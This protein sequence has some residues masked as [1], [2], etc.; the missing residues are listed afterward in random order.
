MSVAQWLHSPD[1][2]ERMCLAGVAASRTPDG[3]AIHDL[4]S[5]AVRRNPR[6]IHLLVSKVLGKHIPVD[7]R[8]VHR[9][10]LELGRL[11]RDSLARDEQVTPSQVLVLGNAETAT[12]LGHSVADALDAAYLHSTRRR[13]PDLP[14]AEE[15]T[16]AHSHAPGHLLQPADPTL[17]DADVVVIVDDELTTGAT[18]LET[19]AAFERLRSGRRYVIATLLDMR[20][21]VDQARVP[22]A[23]TRLGARIEVV[24]LA[25]GE[26]ELAPNAAQLARRLFREKP[27]AMLR[28]QRE[29]RMPGEFEIVEV[30]WPAG[31]PLGGRHGFSV[32]HRAALERVLP[33]LGEQLERVLWPDGRLE[34][35][36]LFLGVEELM[37]APTRLAAALV[38]TL[39][40]RCPAQRVEVRISST[41]RS[42][43][44]VLDAKDYPIRTR[45]TF[46]AHDGTGGER[47]AYNVAAGAGE[48][49]F[50][51]IVL[52]LD[53]PADSP[54]LR[55]RGGLL[56]QLREVADRVVL[57]R[58]PEFRSGGAYSGAHPLPQ[59]LRG[60]GFGSYAPDEVGWLITDLSELALEAPTAEREAAVQSGRAHYAESLPVEY[61]PGP[62]YLAL[63]ADSLARNAP[64]VAHAVGTV[65][66]SIRE[67][68]GRNVVL[69]SLARAGTPVG[70]LLRRWLARHGPAPAHYAVSIVRGRGIDPVALRWLA[71]HHDPAE[72]VFV[73]GWTG[74]G[75]I[76]SELTTALAAHAT[77][78]GPRFDPRLAVLA[79]PGGAAPLVGT[80]ADLL[81]PSACLNSTVSGLVSR[82]VLRADLIGPDDFHGAKF[83]SNLAEHDHS[84]RF[85]DAITAH[86]D[87]VAPGVAPLPLQPVTW[88]GRT[89]VEAICRDERVA[90][91]NF[92][93]PGVGETT[94]VLL[95][96]VPDKVL[97]APDANPDDVAHVRVL[98]AERGV[99]T[100]VR[101][102]LPYQCVGLIRSIHSA[103]DRS[104]SA[105][106]P[107]ATLGADQIPPRS[108][109]SLGG[110]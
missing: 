49:P 96:R 87:A 76:A 25:A 99:P 73:D 60:P 86:F 33:A 102:G 48:P 22:A 18:A 40:D 74:K 24:A 36:V 88:A 94:R 80:R 68:R 13:N 23:E 15:F 51:T 28:S 70:I 21:P 17:L 91:A 78:G 32:E 16:E 54:E 63:F 9:T 50:D 59:P 72:I 106:F 10:G 97:F 92:V 62:E 57:C 84:A 105:L 26:V 77:A 83:H 56:E 107:L 81:V 47:Y 6:R 65:A 45:L 14:I 30:G 66:E 108:S 110:N 95:R 35:R 12:G 42:P 53:P 61:E 31:V 34:G 4:M 101:P 2:V 58:L 19:V 52:V 20:G 3:L 38:D 46:P 98:A 44:V 104:G 11:V 79:D 90:D 109:G 29:L 5:L 93:K 103:V 75:A 55:A 37:Y 1:L 41:T 64:R 27:E 69:V 39:A 89:V 82:T 71:V 43:V 8:V 85:L 67:H 7:P 100:A